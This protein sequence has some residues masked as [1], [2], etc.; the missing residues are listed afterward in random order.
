MPRLADTHCH[1]NFNL[2][3][4]DLP[5]VIRRAEESGIQRILIPGIDLDSCRLAVRLSEQFSTVFAA[6]GVH[7]NDATDWTDTTLREIRVL[8][9][10]PK[11]VAIGEIGLDFHHQR[12][13]HQVQHQILEVQ[14]NLAA[15]LGKPVVLH[16][17]NAFS[18]LWPIIR[19]WHAQLQNLHLSQHPGVFHA[20][21]GNLDDAQLVAQHQFF[22]GIGGPVTYKNAP[23]KQTLARHL[24]LNHILLET[25]AP[26]LSP[27]PFRGQ[28]NEPARIF[29]IAR[30]VANLREDSVSNVAEATSRNAD[31]L[32]GWSFSR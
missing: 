1:L 29:D 20:F 6:V 15:E 5:E 9:Q 14:L 13:P 2:F 25:D 10:H 8:A 7:P 22:I 19:A 17:R 32:L 26:F 11:V 4:E 18:A 30:C 31:Q 27:H 21:E 16:S 23:E 12:S 28:R 24:S 3:N